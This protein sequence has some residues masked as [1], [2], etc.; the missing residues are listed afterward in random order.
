MSENRRRFIK[1]FASGSIL[2]G[3]ALIAS[4]NTAKAAE[5]DG[6]VVTLREFNDE[7]TE[8]YMYGG[9]GTFKYYDN[10]ESSDEREYGSGRAECSGTVKRSSDLKDQWDHS[11]RH[12]EE[13][14][15]V[16]QFN[17][18]S[19]GGSG[20]ITVDIDHDSNGYT[21]YAPFM[22][23]CEYNGRAYYEVS[24]TA[25]IEDEDGNRTYSVSGYV[26]N[27]NPV[28]Y[29]AWGRLSSIRVKPFNNEVRLRR[30]PRTE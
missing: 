22:L 14:L 17:D 19:Q 1:R 8:Y 16:V 18:I 26:E 25:G 11:Y 7:K 5:A 12:G 15:W 9:N 10:L 2:G 21:E 30:D 13:Q 3:T 23:E 20:D 28:D 6:D 27:G 4:S 29:D 24:T